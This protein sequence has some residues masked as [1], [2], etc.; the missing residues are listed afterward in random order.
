MKIFLLL[1][2]I[3]L[4]N[5]QAESQ[6]IKQVVIYGQLDNSAGKII[7]LKNKPLG[8]MG[9]GFKVN[10]ISS[11]MPSGK[12]EF[13]FN[14]PL[15]FPTVLSLEI[16]GETKWLPFIASPGDS[17]LINGSSDLINKA[18]IKGS[19]QDSLFK[20]FRTNKINPI[21]SQFSGRAVS[22]DSF[23]YFMNEIYRVQISFLKNHKNDY[24]SLLVA[25]DL[26]NVKGMDSALLVESKNSFAALNDKLQKS[27]LGKEIHYTFFE[28]PNKYVVGNQITAIT[29]KNENGNDF[30]LTN[31]LK[32]NKLVL[33]DFWA[34]WCAPCIA[35]F[36]ALKNLYSQY[37]KTGFEIISISSDVNLKKYKSF[38]KNNK[39]SWI[40]LNDGLGNSS[41]TNKQFQ[42]TSLPSNYLVDNTGKIIGVNLSVADLKETLEKKLL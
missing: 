38:I 23:K 28:L 31:S 17:I 8:M 12:E 1:L 15:D 18:S 24:V 20:S 35:E 3:I 11:Y 39:L 33:I 26:S 41:P 21:V 2:F 27:E 5:S 25:K 42:I 16:K 29:I 36:P 9:A 30:N 4:I 6:S 19:Y 37:K 22:A 7:L 10:E 40:N 13:F 32:S 14:Q 34:T